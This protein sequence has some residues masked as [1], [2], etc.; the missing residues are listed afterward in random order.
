MACRHYAA[1]EQW[2]EGNVALVGDEQGVRLPSPDQLIGEGGG[3]ERLLQPIH[4]RSLYDGIGEVE[5]PAPRASHHG[6]QRVTS[7][8]QAVILQSEEVVL[9]GHRRQVLGHRSRRLQLVPV[10]KIP[11]ACRRVKFARGRRFQFQDDDR[12]EAGTNERAQNGNLLRSRVD[13]RPSGDQESSLGTPRHAR[14]PG[15]HPL[16]P[17][18]ELGRGGVA[19]AAPECHLRTVGKPMQR[20][21]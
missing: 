8:S 20:R 18:D 6:G 15:K 14:E 5:A 12:C 16:Q 10:R 9:A 7:G 13:A 2:T 19:S 4:R 17:G 21:V 1:L 3:I 11:G